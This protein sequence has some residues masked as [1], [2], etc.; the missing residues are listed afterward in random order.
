[1]DIAVLNLLIEITGAGHSGPMFT[2]YKTI[3]FVV[4]LLNSFYMNSRWTFAG[5]GSES[6]STVS[7]GAQ[8]VAISVV[9]SIVNIASASYVATFLRSP[10]G[11]AHY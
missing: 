8:F 7:Q 1:M 10:V 4:A 2:V 3:S 5:C 11:L 9:A 6:R